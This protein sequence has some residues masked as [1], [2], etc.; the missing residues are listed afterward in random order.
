MGATLTGRRD[1][2]QT[3][4]E[5][6]EPTALEQAR[7]TLDG[8][9]RAEIVKIATDSIVPEDAESFATLSAGLSLDALKFLCART[10]LRKRASETVPTS[11]TLDAFG[12]HRPR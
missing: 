4:K 9:T 12:S 3:A 2:M 5:S 7:A 11:A 10:I 6:E 8:L 1:A